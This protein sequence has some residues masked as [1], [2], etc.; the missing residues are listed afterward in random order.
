M[1]T[2]IVKQ[3][4][5][6]YMCIIS[7]KGILK[8]NCYSLIKRADIFPCHKGQMHFDSYT[9]PD[10][11]PAHAQRQAQYKLRYLI[12]VT[13]CTLNPGQLKSWLP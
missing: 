9:F 7:F 8:E 11:K 3:S 12:H 10:R 13:G 1:L 4:T 6:T 2:V 5:K